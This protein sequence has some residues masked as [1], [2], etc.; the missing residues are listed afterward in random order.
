MKSEQSVR[1]LALDRDEAKQVFAAKA[2]AAMGELVQALWRRS[3]RQA[4]NLDVGLS[5]A[6][7]E[8]RIA[9]GAA[10]APAQA[11][12]TRGGRTLPA[13]EGEAIYLLRPDLVAP[14]SQSLLLEDPALAPL[15]TL[16]TDA[17]AQGAAVLIVYG[18]P[19]V[20]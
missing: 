4:R 20:S 15:R 10:D 7:Y 8:A 5:A 18:A 6:E 14:L 12:L 17:A 19:S 11:L 13:A 2:P 3:D 16:L 9:R 1:F